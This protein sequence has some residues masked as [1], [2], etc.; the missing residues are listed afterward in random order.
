M[1]IGTNMEL[2]SIVVAAAVTHGV[3]PNLLKAI[4]I[5]ETGMKN[6]NVMDKGS[7]SY[8][9]CQVKR[10]AAKQVGMGNVDLEDVEKS[11]AVAALY[12]KHKVSQCN[13]T[14]KAVG[15]YNSGKCI[16]PKSGYVADVLDTYML[17]EIGG[18]IEKSH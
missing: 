8:G 18:F 11:V 4:C 13:N 15:A 5:K 9:P 12:L 6:I 10:V 2:I 1:V 14:M 7:I 16:I 17:L 3:D